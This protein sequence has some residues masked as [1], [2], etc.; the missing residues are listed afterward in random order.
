MSNP[1][2]RIRNVN[3]LETSSSLKLTGVV[4]KKGSTWPCCEILIISNGKERKL[5]V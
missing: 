3:W 2:L 1:E 4:D 5:K